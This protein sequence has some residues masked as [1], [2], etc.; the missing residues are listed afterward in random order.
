MLNEPIPI[1][2][3]VDCGDAGIGSEGG[4]RDDGTTRL[5]GSDVGAD[6]TATVEL[7]LLLLL[8]LV[9][10]ARS[11]DP[12]VVLGSLLRSLGR[13]IRLGGMLVETGVP[14]RK[15]LRLVLEPLGV[16]ARLA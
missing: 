13:P 12:L 7:A 8:V 4:I 10:L 2:R 5:S 15:M 6:G 3:L 11:P 1:L 14:E 16:L 9:A